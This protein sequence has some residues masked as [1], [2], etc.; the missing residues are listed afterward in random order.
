M[1]LTRA[2]KVRLA[3]EKK[4]QKPDAITRTRL[5]LKEAYQVKKLMDRNTKYN[6]LTIDDDDLAQMATKQI[7][8]FISSNTIA[9]HRRAAG[10]KPNRGESASNGKENHGV[11]F[12]NALRPVIGRI[13]VLEKQM[14]SIE[15]FVNVNNQ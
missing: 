14:A 5:T 6:K 1:R 12:A 11:S 15:A 8:A 9:N 3:K 4:E 10:I 7:G 13:E 2:D